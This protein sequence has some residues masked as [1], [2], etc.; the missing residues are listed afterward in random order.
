MQAKKEGLLYYKNDTHWN[1]FGAYVGYRALMDVIQK[2][3]P[4][5][6]ILNLTDFDKTPRTNA[7]GDLSQ[8]LNLPA[9]KYEE[10]TYITLNLKRKPS[11]KYIKNEGPK[12]VATSSIRKLPRT[13]VFR[14][15]FFTSLEPYVS[16][17]LGDTEYI[18]TPKYKDLNKIIEYKPDIVII[19]VVERSIPNLLTQKFT[20]EEVERYAL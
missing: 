18:W 16:E 1:Q 8:M 4:K 12:G 9:T 7:R 11:Y 20:Q 15:S 19:E 14:D 5:L 13:L 3:F 6:Q 17:S 2:D 10:D